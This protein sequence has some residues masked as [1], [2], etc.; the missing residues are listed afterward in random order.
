MISTITPGV[1]I[2]FTTVIAEPFS[3]VTHFKI[4]GRLRSMRTTNRSK[5]KVSRRRL[6]PNFYGDETVTAQC[7]VGVLVNRDPLSPDGWAAVMSI[8]FT[9]K[10]VPIPVVSIFVASSHERGSY[11]KSWVGRADMDPE[12]FLK[13]I[14]ATLH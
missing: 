5:S 2:D 4:P 7:A 12:E 14:L 9:D 3:D 13:E 11:G 1:A 8:V 10:P 6:D